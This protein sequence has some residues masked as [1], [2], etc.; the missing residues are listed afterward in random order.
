MMDISDPYLALLQIIDNHPAIIPHYIMAM[1]ARG[2]LREREGCHPGAPTTC[3]AL[4]S[5][6]R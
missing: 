6:K 2:V 1:I 4:G 3:L 5:V